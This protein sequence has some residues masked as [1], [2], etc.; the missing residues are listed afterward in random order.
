[1]TAKLIITGFMATGKSS[2][3][4]LV[5]RRLGWQFA[6]TDLVVVTLAGKSVPEIFALHGESYFR[7]L[8]REAIATLTSARRHCPQCG[9]PLP[10]VISTGGG[11][12]LDEQNCSVLKRAGTVVCLTARPQTIA[13]R[14]GS[15]A[16]R[17]PKL[18]E[19]GQP[20]EQRIR[21][22]MAE[23]AGAYARAD[24]TIDTSD[25]AP[26]EVAERVIDAF[27]QQ[28]QSRCKAFA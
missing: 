3:G 9:N 10:S 17:R 7:A 6:D 16:A 13:V 20:L 11:A 26:E 2:V 27:A 24:V 1:V 21:S 28:E 23:R 19:G 14:V 15:S 5:A 22:L 12:L 8:E 18:T 25:L 4:H